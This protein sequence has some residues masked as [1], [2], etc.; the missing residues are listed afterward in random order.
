MPDRKVCTHITTG[1]HGPRRTT[2]QLCRRESPAKPSLPEQAHLWRSPSSNFAR[3]RV[4][5]V[6]IHEVLASCRV[7]L[8][9]KPHLCQPSWSDPRAQRRHAMMF[10]T[11]PMSCSHVGLPEKAHLGRPGSASR[12]SKRVLKGVGL[13]SVPVEPHL[14]RSS[15][16][17]RAVGHAF[18]AEQRLFCLLGAFVDER[19]AVAAMPVARV[20]RRP[21]ALESIEFITLGNL[22][23]IESGRIQAA[24]ALQPVWGSFHGD[25]GE[26]AQ[27]HG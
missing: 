11:R 6:L 7:R 5:D 18:L 14:S 20:E 19:H 26:P 25:L 21:T 17:Q 10:P 23:Y 22:E 1:R 8:P 2:F 3:C 12:R 13:F 16:P 15:S 27:G 4:L 24:C 9:E